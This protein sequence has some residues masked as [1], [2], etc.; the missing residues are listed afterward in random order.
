M[1]RVIVAALLLLA[2]SQAHAQAA[3]FSADDVTILLYREP[4]K[5]T[6]SVSNLPH[7]ATWAEK[8]KTY[9][10]CFGTTPFGVLS[11]YFD[12]DKTVA[13]IPTHVFQPAKGI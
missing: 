5:L 10:G 8:G 2:S 1:K 4:C 3:V 12:G 11:F 13:T 9:E 7:R 6:A